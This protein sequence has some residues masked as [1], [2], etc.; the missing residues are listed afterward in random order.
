M[1]A[2]FNWTPE[3][4]DICL[5]AGQTAWRVAELVHADAAQASPFCPFVKEHYGALETT[6]HTTGGRQQVHCS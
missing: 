6:A 2:I 1:C 5:S 4:R 3:S